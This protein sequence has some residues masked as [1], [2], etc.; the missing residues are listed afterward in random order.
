M[1]VRAL[2]YSLEKKTS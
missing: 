1:Y 2:L